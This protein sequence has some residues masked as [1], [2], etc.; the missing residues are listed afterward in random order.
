M[1]LSRTSCLRVRVNV[2]I[3]CTGRGG[4]FGLA[5]GDREK[6]ASVL[7]AEAEHEAAG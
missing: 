4:T 1:A 6:I 5:P 3:S 7:A 2:R